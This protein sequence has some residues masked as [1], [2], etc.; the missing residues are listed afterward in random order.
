M[1]VSDSAFKLCILTAYRFY[2][3]TM[4]YSLSTDFL[5]GAVT[6]VLLLID[7]PLY[8]ST[9]DVEQ[10]TRTITLAFILLELFPFKLCH[11]IVSAL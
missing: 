6:R 3:T 10:S 7:Q 4:N 8:I 2:L 5:N 1:L 9:L 11:N